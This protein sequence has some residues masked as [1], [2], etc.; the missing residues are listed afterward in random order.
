MY[1]RQTYEGTTYPN[2]LY[3]VDGVLTIKELEN[4]DRVDA[5]SLAEAKATIQKNYAEYLGTALSLIHIYC[6]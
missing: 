2:G 6:Q 4:Q 5:A 1:K 3:S